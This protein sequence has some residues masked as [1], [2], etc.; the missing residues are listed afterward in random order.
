[1]SRFNGVLNAS[2]FSDVFTLI[3]NSLEKKDKVIAAID[4]NSGAGKSCLA[5]LIARHFECNI[6]HMDDFFLQPHQRS[7]ERF[8]EPGGN[9]DYERFKAEVIDNLMTLK[10]FR[11]QLYDCSK[12][13]LTEWVQV[14]PR[15]LNIIE[16]VYSMHPSW[17]KELDVKIFLTVNPELQLKR[18]RQRNGELLLRRFVQEWIPMEN[19]YFEACNI[20][21][22]CDLVIDTGFR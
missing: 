4:G 8:Q 17:N 9:I 20:K 1:M 6:F 13:A 21:E 7:P 18:I 19:Y 12:Q 14:V 22:Q 3:S 15:K 11:Y 5:D 16:G 10:E 2:D